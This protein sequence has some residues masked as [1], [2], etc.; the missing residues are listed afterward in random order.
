[1]VQSHAKCCWLP[2]FLGALDDLGRPSSFS[3]FFRILWVRWISNL[4]PG[5][6]RTSFP[7]H[8]C[9][10][11]ETDW[12]QQFSRKLCDIG[13]CWRNLHNLVVELQLLAEFLVWGQRMRLGSIC[14]LMKINEMRCNF[15]LLWRHA[16]TMPMRSTTLLDVLAT[17]FSSLQVDD[18]VS[19]APNNHDE[20]SKF[21]ILN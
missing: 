5:E 3:S 12:A 9:A 13:L 8:A 10:T 4:A 17:I 11:T 14:C 2:R 15:V 20:S 6:F 18:L 21:L 16:T 7:S 1:M 19:P